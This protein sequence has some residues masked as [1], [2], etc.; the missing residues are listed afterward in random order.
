MC[1]LATLTF[2]NPSPPTNL[3]L[4]LKPV[5]IHSTTDTCGFKSALVVK[6]ISSGMCHDPPH[7]S[8]PYNVDGWQL[9]LIYM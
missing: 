3:L 2:S 5:F 7:S 1:Q 9:V 8:R 6:W 4:L